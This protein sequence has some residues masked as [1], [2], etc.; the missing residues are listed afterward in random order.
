[1]V[2]KK[3]P[4]IIISNGDAWT[5]PRFWGWGVYYKSEFEESNMKEYS[6][7]ESN[8]ELYLTKEQLEFLRG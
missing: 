6:W 8:C 2:T 3:D 4:K 5:P 7:V 1:M